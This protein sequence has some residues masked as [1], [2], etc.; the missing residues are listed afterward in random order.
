LITL[1]ARE[2]DL[3]TF[4][5]RGDISIPEVTEAYL[6]FLSV[7]SPL[8]LWDLREAKIAGERDDLALWK[9]AVTA[10]T[11]SKEHRATGKTA[12]VCGNPQDFNHAG[13]LRTYLRI[14]GYPV[15]V[16]EFVDIER[17]RSWLKGEPSA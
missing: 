7:P 3:T 12:I 6:N 9:L 11:S 1:R 4:V 8:V 5:G 17:A 16:R 14:A 13:T 15:Q 2:P 10:A